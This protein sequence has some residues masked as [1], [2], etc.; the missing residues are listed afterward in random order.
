MKN[1][2]RD[3][4]YIIK[5]ILIGVGIAIILANLRKCNVYAETTDINVQLTQGPISFT[6]TS[7][8]SNRFLYSLPSPFNN[9]IIYNYYSPY[10]LQIDKSYITFY[11]Q[12]YDVYLYYFLPTISPFD[13]DV[14][15]IKLEWSSE[16]NSYIFYYKCNDIEN[17]DF[18]DTC[19]ENNGYQDI[20][21]LSYSFILSNNNNLD[22]SNIISSTYSSDMNRYDSPLNNDYFY[23]YYGTAPVKEDFFDNAVVYSSEDI[24]SFSINGE[25]ISL[26]PPGYS[27]IDLTD[28]QAVYF[29]PKDY[30]DIQIESIQTGGNDNYPIYTNFIDFNYYFKGSIKQAYFSL[31]DTDI[32]VSTFQPRT[33]LEQFE[34][35][36]SFFPLTE[37]PDGTG[38]QYLSYL[39]YNLNISDETIIYYNSVLFDYYLVDNMSDYQNEVCFIDREHNNKCINV[40]F[41]KTLEDIFNQGMQQSDDEFNDNNNDSIKLFLDL[42]KLPF[43]FINRLKKTSCFPLNLTL[44]FINYNLS[45]PCLSSYFKNYF[46]NYY[47]LIQVLI[48]GILL[49]K[50]FLI[51]FYAVLDVIK[52]QKSQVEV[53]DL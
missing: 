21:G 1:V 3:T 7:L 34:Y 9:N 37:N 23:N 50:V 48:S 41:N 35:V 47:S 38:Y 51:N 15:D 33:N 30:N 29:V 39:I 8:D 26:I 6:N 12:L 42:I 36:D 32:M 31:D 16:T 17:N 18:K 25:E 40:I 24:H 27:R 11:N 44:P 19:L 45:L 2:Q 53:V 5:R 10:S 22:L 49:Y 20:T 4:K 28:Y 13:I 46:K 52:P 14:S 43:N